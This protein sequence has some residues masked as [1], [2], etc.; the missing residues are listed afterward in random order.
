MGHVHLQDS[1]HF[2]TRT[3]D[4]GIRGHWYGSRRNNN[5]DTYTWRNSGTIRACGRR[6]R[7]QHL[8]ALFFFS[9]LKPEGRLFPK[10]GV[11]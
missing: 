7:P 6:R 4:T 1:G 10:G 8:K 3:L 11:M 9:L 2:R 5:Y